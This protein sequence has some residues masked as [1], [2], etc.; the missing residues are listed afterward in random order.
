MRTAL[1][2]MKKQ[3]VIARDALTKFSLKIKEAEAIYKM[4]LAA[5]KVVKLS[6]SAEAQVFA[7][8]KEQVAF[9]AVRTQLNRSFAELNRAVERRSESK[10]DNRQKLAQA[11]TASEVSRRTM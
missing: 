4:S 11:Q 1:D 5:Q 8:I 9:D 2:D 3:Q 6:K 7:Q 10:T